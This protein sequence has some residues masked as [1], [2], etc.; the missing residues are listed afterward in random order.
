M[1][2]TSKSNEEIKTRRRLHWNQVM[3]K[4]CSHENP[5]CGLAC[6]WSGL[7]VVWPACGLA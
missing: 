5:A 4:I 3:L 7:R 6:V 2:N 1:L